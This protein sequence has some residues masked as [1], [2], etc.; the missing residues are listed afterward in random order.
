MVGVA[1]LSF[2][3]STFPEA[4]GDPRDGALFLAWRMYCRYNLRFRIALF[5]FRAPAAFSSIECFRVASPP[6]WPFYLCT[7]G[8]YSPS[9][10]VFLS[11]LPTSVVFLPHILPPLSVSRKMLPSPVP[12]VAWQLLDAS[13]DVYGS[14]CWRRFSYED[15]A[16]P[17]SSLTLPDLVPRRNKNE[18]GAVMS[19]K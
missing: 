3:S 12:F 19:T 2:V 13:H 16:R 7:A 6:S 15:H 1:I 18:L 4:L 9:L 8:S 17:T 5:V 11:I 14:L 10:F